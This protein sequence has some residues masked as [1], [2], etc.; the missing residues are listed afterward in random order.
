MGVF[1]S[2]IN[3]QTE[4]F[5]KLIQ[6]QHVPSRWLLLCQHYF[7]SMR[8]A[9]CSFLVFSFHVGYF[10][11]HKRGDLTRPQD[12]QFVLYVLY[13][14]LQPCNKKAFCAAMPFYPFGGCTAQT[15]HLGMPS[16][17]YKVFVSCSGLWWFSMLIFGLKAT[18]INLNL[19]VSQASAVTT[20]L[21]SQFT[22]NRQGDWTRCS[23]RVPNIL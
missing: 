7:V 17:C 20:E 3:F 19:Q 9:C 12:T 4:L 1:T 2:L 13:L 8:Q 23:F 14:L 22:R 21:Q 11:P 5:N 10:Y 18:G 6:E 16:Q 15:E